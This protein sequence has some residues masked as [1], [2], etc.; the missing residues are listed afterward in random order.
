MAG[1][2]ELLPNRG[3]TNIIGSDKDGLAGKMA[4]PDR[5]Y[6]GLV[7]DTTY[8]QGK[9]TSS[10]AYGKFRIPLFTK[11]SLLGS[12]ARFAN[13]YGT[14]ETSLGTTT[15]THMGIEYNGAWMG[16][17]TFDS[18][19]LSKVMTATDI[20]ST[21]ACLFDVPAGV[22]AFLW[23][24]VNN[25]TGLPY[26]PAVQYRHLGQRSASAITDNLGTLVTTGMSNAEWTFSPITIEGWTKKHS[27]VMLE[28]SRGVDGYNRRGILAP[29]D[30]APAI[31]AVAAVANMGM[32]GQAMWQYGTDSTARDKS[33]AVLA[34]VTTAILV[35]DMV[36]DLSTDAAS[37]PGLY[38]K[39]FNKHDPAGK[40]LRIAK[41][42]DPWNSLG[43][44]AVSALSQ[45]AGIATATVANA[46][47]LRVGM[48]VVIAGATPTAFN[49][50]KVITGVDYTANTFTFAI[51]SATASPAT[52]TLTY[53]DGYV[54]QT[55]LASAT[56]EMN[57]QSGNYQLRLG[58]VDGI[59]FVLD[60]ASV[61][62]DQ[63]NPSFWAPLMN[64]AQDNTDGLHVGRF[65]QLAKSFKARELAAVLASTGYIAP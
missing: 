23:V 63:T 32:S 19:S 34:P 33:M 16:D 50:T 64:P 56:Q 5:P 17:L 28:N 59:Q 25:P 9:F 40:K 42:C 29:G 7:A 14:G 22:L 45:A 4:A 31:A 26:C 55:L 53:K 52:G 57:R 18:G 30:T 35:G 61:V 15:I 62:E 65:G 2:I 41:T 13:F 36:N 8:A 43:T 44:G 46:S 47:K 60:T 48:S 10:D 21:D 20:A 11:G 27:V 58:A 39:I 51:A 6:W 38:T 49:G 37:L 24:M 1:E 12:V 3:L 54:G